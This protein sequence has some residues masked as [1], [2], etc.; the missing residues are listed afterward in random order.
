MSLS[1]I[2]VV[3]NALRLPGRRPRTQATADPAP[4][5]LAMEPAR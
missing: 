2:L 4:G 3:T 5:Q 1:S